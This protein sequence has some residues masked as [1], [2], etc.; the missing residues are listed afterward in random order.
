MALEKYEKAMQ[1]LNLYDTFAESTDFVFL[2]ALIWMDNG[3]IDE[4][5]RAFRRAVQMPEGRVEGVNSYLAYY[6]MGVIQ[7]CLGNK[8]EAEEW[9]RKASGYKR[10]EERLLN[11]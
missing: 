4:A 7:E 5:M 3:F 8:A 1:L 9:Y 2:S 6:N 10:A 11:L